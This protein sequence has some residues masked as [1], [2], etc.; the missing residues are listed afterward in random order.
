MTINGQT[1]KDAGGALFSQASTAD[2]ARVNQALVRRKVTIQVTDVGTAGNAI[3][4]QVCFRA[5]VPCK[6]ISA[7]LSPGIAITG[8]DT[9]FCNLLLQKR[10]ASA[11]ASPVTVANMQTTATTPTPSLGAGPTT[12]FTPITLTNSATGANLVL[13]AGDVLTFTKNGVNGT[14]TAIGAAA[15]AAGAFA[16]L[17]L[18]IEET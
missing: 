17:T 2:Q 1:L 16:H 5:E 9:N 7:E 4:E 13:V 11:P 14:G 12:A 6:L 10:P 18:E 3:G 15:T 8:S